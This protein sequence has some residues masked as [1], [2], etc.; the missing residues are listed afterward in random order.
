MLTDVE[1]ADLA[2]TLTDEERSVILQQ[3]TERPLLYRNLTRLEGD[4]CPF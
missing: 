3:G 4:K 1:G 2:E